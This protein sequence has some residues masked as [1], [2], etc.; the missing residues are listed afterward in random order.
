MPRPNRRE[1][2]TVAEIKLGSGEGVQVELVK[3]WRIKMF[4]IILL[5]CSLA[6]IQIGQ[7]LLILLVDALAT[8]IAAYYGW[9][10]TCISRE[11]L[12]ER[13]SGDASADL[14]WAVPSRRQSRL[15]ARRLQLSLGMTAHC[16]LF[17]R[18]SARGYAIAH[19]LN[20]YLVRAK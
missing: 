1:D 6:A 12:L 5:L 15:L 19:V 10:S 11:M 14:A 20:R 13:P 3:K 4:A 17:P 7:W 9:R 8:A 16:S 18:S 2:V